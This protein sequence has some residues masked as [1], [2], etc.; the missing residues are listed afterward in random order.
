MEI[1]F[2][3]Q[4]DRKFVRGLWATHESFQRG[5][6]GGGNRFS[7]SWPFYSLPGRL[8][9]N[10]YFLGGRLTPKKLL[11][12][13]RWMFFTDK[14]IIFISSRNWI[15][16]VALNKNFSIFF[17][18]RHPCLL[19]KCPCLERER[20]LTDKKMAGVRASSHRAC[21]PSPSQV[22]PPRTAFIP[23]LSVCSFFRKGFS[24][25]DLA[26]TSDQCVTSVPVSFA[27][28]IFGLDKNTI[29]HRIISYN[30]NKKTC[31]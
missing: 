22:G 14:E 24:V 26:L 7:Q 8:L 12:S 31:K 25:F 3:S 29:L 13:I 11:Y 15:L 6:G 19:E 4:L 30:C 1:F 28:W 17:L 10:K 16:K 21:P 20:A 27:S 18:S 2:S 9:K 5:V 23:S